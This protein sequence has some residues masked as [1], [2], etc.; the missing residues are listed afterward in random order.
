MRDLRAFAPHAIMLRTLHVHLILTVALL[1]ASVQAQL[2]INEAS[3]RNAHT[4]ADAAGKYHDWLELHNAGPN[5]V[6]LTGYTLTD[7][8]LDPAQWVF[9]S[10]SLAPNGHLLVFCSGEDRGPR[11]GITPVAQ[12]T[13]FTP[14]NGWNTHTLSAPFSWDGN[15]NLLIQFCGLRGNMG[16]M[17]NA[18]FQQTTTSFASSANVFCHDPSRTCGMPYGDLSHRR[19]VMRLNGNTIGT[20]NWL[21]AF[22]QLPAPYANWQGGAKQAYLIQ[23]SELTAAGLTAGPINTLAFN[24]VNTHGAALE[25][26]DIHMALTTETELSATFKPTNA[27]NELHTNFKLGR[28][29]E[30]V[31]LH[32]PGGAR[33]DSLYVLQSAPNHSNGR[34]QDGGSDDRIFT[35]PTPGASNNTAVAYN[36]YATAP[37][38]STSPAMSQQPV[39]VIIYNTNTAPSEVRYTLNGSEPTASSAL[40]T[41]PLTISNSAVLKARVFRSGYAPSTVASA[42]YL[43]GVQHSTAVISVIT[44]NSSLYGP[45]G[46]FTNWQR[47]DEVQAHVDYFRPSG[48]LIVSQFAGMQVDGGLGGSRGFPQHSFRLEFDN[49]ALGD[50]RV[51]SPLIPDRPARTRYSRIYLRNGSN[52]Y[53]ILPHKD[54]AQVKMMAAET[55]S[56]FAAWTPATVYINGEYFGVYELREKYDDEYFRTLENADPGTVDLLSVSAWNG[57]VLRPTEGQVDQFWRDFSA[58]QLLDPAQENFW[59]N[60]DARFDLTWY[61]DYIIGQQWMGTR[62]WPSNNIKIQRSDVT[63]YKWRFCTVDLELALAPNGQSDAQFDALTY[64]GTQPTDIPYSRIWQRAIQ[65]PRFHDHFINR[66]ADVMNSAYLNDRLVGIANDFYNRTRP[67]MGRQ[68]QRWSSTDT[69]IA[70]AQYDANQAAF[71]SDLEQRTPFVRDH[72]QGFF[73]LPR[74]VDVTLD[75]VPAGAGSIRISTLHPTSYPWEG[76]Y[77][78]GVPIHIEAV[79]NEGYFFSHWTPDAVIANMMSA[80]FL[81]TLEANTALFQANFIQDIPTVLRERDVHLLTV[82]PNPTTGE[83]AVDLRHFADAGTITYQ[84]FDMQGKLMYEAS[85]GATPRQVLSLHDLHNGSYQLRLTTGDG[86]RAVARFVKL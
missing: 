38:L 68:F 73:D 1:P 17:L 41:A 19:P 32:A 21:N 5:A 11:A 18:V 57:Y 48:Q 83:L 82:V 45:N 81:D 58:F 31:Y 34:S 12:F 16:G 39:N 3:S 61:T 27:S 60:T 69:T 62:D 24:V 66:F 59:E 65:N 42:S 40:Y 6:D 79:A 23:A 36:G 7:D 85:H 56:Y 72:I 63:N 80:T 76:V 35:T 30:T 22:V 51:N 20:N 67:E 84:V 15:S 9:P 78:D 13:D 54:A 70:L 71:V 10:V 26:L 29:G 55:N 44:P 4:V 49:D 64:T 50:G 77:F 43:I 28:T 74:Q 47:D 86:Q 25:T 33:L 52:Q 75:V 14:V 8:P 53:Q 37:I 46:I 2:T